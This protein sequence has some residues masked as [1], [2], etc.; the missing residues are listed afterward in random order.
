MI[1]VP[2]EPGLS[3]NNSLDKRVSKQSVHSKQDVHSMP[4]GAKITHKPKLCEGVSQ[5]KYEPKCVHT[6]NHKPPPPRNVQQVS[7]D[8]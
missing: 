3:L 7:E 5:V 8:V 1:N 6:T 2:N 4:A